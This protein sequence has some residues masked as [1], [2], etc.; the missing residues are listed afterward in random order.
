MKCGTLGQCGL[1]IS[2][3]VRDTL[4][5]VTTSSGITHLA[6]SKPN[7]ALVPFSVRRN[8]L[9]STQDR[10][11]LSIVLTN[12]EQDVLQLLY[13]ETMPWIIQFY[14]HTIRVHADDALRGKKHFIHDLVYTHLPP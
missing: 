14:L 8:L 10:G 9:G 13:L 1:A 11:Q 3:T 7:P 4:L 5:F 6:L 12:N 2:N